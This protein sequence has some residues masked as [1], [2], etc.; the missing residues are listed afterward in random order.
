M[1]KDYNLEEIPYREKMLSDKQ[2]YD[3]LKWYVL[4]NP[5]EVYFKR[6]PNCIVEGGE[7]KLNNM[8]P[9]RIE[10]NGMYNFDSVQARHCMKSGTD[11]DKTK[12]KFDKPYHPTTMERIT[13]FVDG[14]PIEFVRCG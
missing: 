11:E 6:K 10:I 12:E 5:D 7:D 1:D 13:I 2:R 3:Y 14:E 9:C 8:F 4:T